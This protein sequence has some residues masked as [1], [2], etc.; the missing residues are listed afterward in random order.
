MEFYSDDKQVYIDPT[1]EIDSY[2]RRA[3]LKHWP[4]KLIY[5]P[6]PWLK[7]DECF[8]S[9]LIKDLPT[10]HP[11]TKLHL[12]KGK[13]LYCQGLPGA[14]LT[15]ILIEE[16][17]GLGVQEIIF[18]GIAGSIQPDITIGNR[19]I[20]TEAIRLEGTSYHYLPS[21]DSAIASSQMRKDLE[22]FLAAQ[23]VPF[24]IGKICSTDA[25]FRETFTLIETLQKQKALAIDMEISA[26]F[27]VA[28]FREIKVVA[29]L[30]ISDQL[31]EEQ[32]TGIKS[33]E[34][35]KTYQESLEQ[36]YD[37]FIRK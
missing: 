1:K 32:W 25:P 37:F 17:I 15:C 19:M 6:I 31:I 7:V 23:G 10:L 20:V 26:V 35:I 3:D 16:L 21:E 33:K 13:V 24:H 22:E 27:S 12:L 18:L 9:V 4:T 2:R 28:L 29:L 8:S 11:G 34:I 36:C 14:P 5:Q 30:V